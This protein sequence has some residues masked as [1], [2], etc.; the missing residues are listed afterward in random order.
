MSET[1]PSVNPAGAS[2]NKNV[3]ESPS[4][5]SKAP[6]SSP[7]PPSRLN[8]KLCSATAYDPEASITGLYTGP[9]FDPLAPRNLTAHLGDRARCPAQYD[10]WGTS[11]IHHTTHNQHQHT[12]NNP[13]HQ[14]QHPLNHTTSPPTNTQTPH[15]HHTTPTPPPQHPPHS[16]VLERHLERFV[17]LVHERSYRLEF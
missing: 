2:A 6:C 11:R 7:K 16:S 5:S 9:Y 8:H 13:L 1:R 10:S 3:C 17:S 14:T 15:P 12:R 4:H